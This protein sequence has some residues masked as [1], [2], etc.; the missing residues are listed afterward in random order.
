MWNSFSW[1]RRLHHK[2]KLIDWQ[3]KQYRRKFNIKVSLAFGLA[4]MAI[5]C[6]TGHVSGGNKVF[7]KLQ[8]KWSVLY[9]KSESSSFC[10]TIGRGRIVS[11]QMYSLYC[12][13]KSWI[14]CRKVDVFM[15]FKITNSFWFTGA[16]ILHYVSLESIPLG[17]NGVNKTLTT[18]FG[19]FIMEMMLTML[20]VLV[21]YS[22]AVDKGNNS[23]PM[24]P[25][26]LIGLTVTVAHLVC[27]P[28]TG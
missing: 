5:A 8:E 26:L 18:P 25:P 7:T 28:Y 22:T 13:S 24:L 23:S 11:H 16:T 15:E 6:F 14:S 10:W 17:V 12:C 1:F 4:V 9:R 27:I 3:K 20:L 21:V 19:G 2:S